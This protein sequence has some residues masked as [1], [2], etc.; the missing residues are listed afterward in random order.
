MLMW[1]FGS[2]RQAY[3]MEYI[4]NLKHIA[5]PEGEKQ[6]DI[7]MSKNQALQILCL[8]HHKLSWIINLYEIQENLIFM[9][10]KLP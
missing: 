4:H 1:Q 10:T 2:N 8:K 9:K 7:L 5:H 6:V 3:C